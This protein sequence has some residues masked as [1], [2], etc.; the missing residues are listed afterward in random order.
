ML[1][2]PLKE[3]L[4]LSEPGKT[5]DS[6]SI[7]TCRNAFETLKTSLLTNSSD[8]PTPSLRIPG[9]DHLDNPVLL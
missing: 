3:G 9:A 7:A 4:K 6:E 8:H 1:P 2:G 5:I